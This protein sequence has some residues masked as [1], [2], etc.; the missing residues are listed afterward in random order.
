MVSFLTPSKMDRLFTPFLGPGANTALHCCL[1]S[2]S[3]PRAGLSDSTVGSE[4]PSS[5]C[6]GWGSAQS[7][8][9]DF[10]LRQAI[11]SWVFSLTVKVSAYFLCKHWKN[12]GSE[13]LNSGDVL[14]VIRSKDCSQNPKQSLEWASEA[15]R[16]GAESWKGEAIPALTPLALPL[17]PEQHWGAP[18]PSP[19]K[20]MPGTKR[21]K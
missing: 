1:F 20:H 10:K 15:S 3:D 9:P 14:G 18:A 6:K 2:S 12:K 4:L 11:I 16:R 17:L 21:F 13:D 7:Y 5:Y 19:V 8:H